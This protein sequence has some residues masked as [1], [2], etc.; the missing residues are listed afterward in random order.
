LHAIRLHAFGPPENLRYEEL[1]DPVPAAGQVR[2][3]VRASGVHFIDAAIRRGAAGGF[4][5]P[6]LPA[7]PGREVAGEVDAVGQGVDPRWLGRRVVA[8]LGMAGGGYAE[9]AVASAGVLH[10][11]PEHVRPEAAVA[12]IGTGRTAMWLLDG[13]A[14]GSEDVVVV[15]A[16]AGG[17]GSLLVQ[18]ARAAGAVVVGLAGG[19]EKTAHARRSGAHA[20]VDYRADDW[21]D[22]AREA[23][24]ASGA[25]VVLDGVGGAVGRAAM[26]LLGTGGR[27]VLFGWASGEVTP[28]TAQDLV[29]RSL[30]V[31]WGI[32]PRLLERPGGLHELE[33]RALAEVAAGRL[34]PLVGAPSPSSGPP[35]PTPRW[36][37]VR[38]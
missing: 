38:R 24:G 3:A 29:A 5:L 9:R 16:A 21:R 26:E 35:R 22:R 14:A 20:A 25:T 36:S 28:L 8:H 37:P 10:E 13:V 30:T 32:G 2:V 6:E 7:I 31:S 23:V 11:V 17:L 4:P 27:L 18:G 12:A 1:P 34:V 15:T 33:A 19:P